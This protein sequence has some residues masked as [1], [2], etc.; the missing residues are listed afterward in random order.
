MPNLAQEAPAYP[1]R[2]SYL[3]LHHEPQPS[4]RES[5][6]WVRCQ[7]PGRPST[8][9]RKNTP[10]GAQ[11]KPK[12]ANYVL[13][14]LLRPTLAQKAPAYPQKTSFFALQR[15]PHPSPQESRK[16]VCCHHPCSRR[17]S[18][19][20]RKNAPPGAQKKTKTSKF[21]LC[22]P[23]MPDLAQKAPAYPQKSSFFA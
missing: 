23:L 2:S 12:T 17:P 18:A 14:A 20:A 19:R 6:N 7:Y 21:A 3:G 15:S 10:L 8:W 5:R 4:S 11:K 9:V 22:A 1:Q 16:W 13:C